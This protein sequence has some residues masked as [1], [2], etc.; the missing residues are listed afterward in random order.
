MDTSMVLHETDK[1]S[2]LNK[3]IALSAVLCSVY[4]VLAGIPINQFIG[5]VAYVSAAIC[6]VSL[7]GYALG[8]SRGAIAGL[9]GGVLSAALFPAYFAVFTVPLGPALAGFQVGLIRD[10]SVADTR[11]LASVSLHMT[12]VIALYLVKDSEAWWF[13]LPYGLAV[14]WV[15]MLR[16]LPSRLRMNN[17]VRMLTMALIGSMADF[18]MMTLG[19][20]YILELPA[21]VFG[22]II[23]PMMV[24]ERTISVVV[25]ATLLQAVHK[26][27][28]LPELGTPSKA[29]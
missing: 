28:L 3:K 29:D 13:V 16:I 19:A 10:Y 6:F 26:S 21:Y 14:V 17:A 25:G 23:F 9:I 12:A 22:Y 1:K 20:V 11:V 7:F 24:L 27:Q 8:A 2:E 4:I 15:W 5:S 18:S